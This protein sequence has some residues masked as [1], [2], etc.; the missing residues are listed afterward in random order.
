MIVPTISIGDI[1]IDPKDFD[2]IWVGTGEANNQRSSLWGDGV[3]KST[4]RGKT[5]N[6]TGLVDSHHIGRIV[7]DPNDPEVVYVAALVR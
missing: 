3:Y 5:W 6:N 2:V 1:A 4:D 7:I